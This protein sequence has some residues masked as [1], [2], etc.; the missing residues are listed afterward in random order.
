MDRRINVLF[1]MVRVKHGN[2]E[3]PAWF[4]TAR[5][6]INIWLGSFGHFLLALS[7]QFG[8]ADPLYASHFDEQE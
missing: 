3:C 5:G 1:I 4:G 6:C 2:Y 7:F 8:V